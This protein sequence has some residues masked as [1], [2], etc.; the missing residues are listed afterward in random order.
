M[1]EEWFGVC[2]IRREAIDGAHLI[3]PRESYFALANLWKHD[4]YT[5][6][7]E[8]LA[9][10]SLDEAGIIAS[11]KE[12]AKTTEGLLAKAEVPYAKPV[13]LDLP[14]A[15]Y[16]EAGG[17]QPWAASGA[18]PDPNF[19]RL[20]FDCKTQ[21]HVGETCLRVSYRSG[22]DWSAMMW[23]HPAGDWDNNSPGGFDLTGATELS[24]WA[25]GKQGG[26]KAKISIGGPLTGFYPNT[27]S[28]ELGEIVLGT[29]WKEYI[30]PLA[31]KDLRRIKNPL[32]IAVAGSGFPF[33]FYLD[34]V[35]YR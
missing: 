34:E 6:G 9:A 22:G 16:R 30:I 33:E 26:E 31:G 21:P 14:V 10:L 8:G 7:V 23:Q 1:N 29:E 28:A 18:M 12:A 25:R 24:F 27:V 17:E 4:P 13:K 19:I 5:L 11:T 32:T 2:S 15:V 20:E 3:Q 35:I